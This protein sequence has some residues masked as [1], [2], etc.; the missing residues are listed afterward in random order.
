MVPGDKIPFAQND[1][2]RFHRHNQQEE[3]D[4]RVRGSMRMGHSLYG[5]V[6]DRLKA[7]DPTIVFTQ[8]KAKRQLL[9][10][11]LLV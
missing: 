1:V 3:I 5:L 6:E 9:Y 11:R 10:A 8:G 2:Q 7:A 4:R